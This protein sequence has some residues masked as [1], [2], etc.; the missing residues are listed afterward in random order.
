[1]S[2]QRHDR[3]SPAVC[4]VIAV[5]L[6]LAAASGVT[7][8]ERV[9]WK[10]QSAIP[11]NLPVIGTTGKFVSEQIS[12]ISGGTFKLIWYE[13]N[14]LV[15]PL[16]GLDAVSVGAVDAF[17][18]VSG[19]WVGRI[20]SAPLFTSHPFGP[21]PEEY[22]AWIEHGGGQELWDELYE[23][24]GVK[25]IPC[26]AIGPEASGWFQSEIKSVEDLQ[27]LKIRYPGYAGEVL[28]ALGASTQ[29]LAASDVYS[30]LERGTL[31]AAE[32]SMPAVDLELGLHRMVK[33][34]YFPGWH[35]PA[36]IGELLVNL[37]RWE[38]LSEVHRAQL[39]L[40][41][42]AAIQRSLI[43]SN[44][45]QGDALEAMRSDGVLIHRWPPELMDAFRAAWDEVVARRS[46]EDATFRRVWESISAFRKEYA[47]WQELGVAE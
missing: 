43:E 34:Y 4:R 47:V 17:Y 9:E 42:K 31:D 33:H 27:G 36:T 25:G 11:G 14:A 46:A 40:I 19:F 22:L 16:E 20:R 38:A 26:G 1:M 18:G 12:M 29:M 21:G 45:I 15:P 30:A 7:A 8:Q 41:C 6:A 35:Q 32:F 28:Q 23:P 13:P 44:A 5:C 10:M 2:L 39:E 3:P 37:E 24:W